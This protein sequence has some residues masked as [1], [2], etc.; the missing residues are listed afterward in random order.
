MGTTRVIVRGLGNVGQD[1]I[2]MINE[3]KSLELVGVLD[4]DPAKVGKDSGVF[5][6]LSANG[7]TVSD[8]VDAVLALPADVVLD[9]SPTLRDD[10]GGFTPSAD[11]ICR[12]LKAGK[13]VITT[14]PLYFLNATAPK[15]YNQLND[16]AKDHGVTFLPTGLLPGAYA[17]YIPIV[18]A[19]IMGRVDSVV[20]ASGED[21]QLNTSSWVTVFGYGMDPATFPA[22]RLKAGI[23]SYYVSAVY[24]MGARLG[25]TFDEVRSTHEVF[26]APQD[27]HPVWGT[28]AKG[29]IYGH[30]FTMSGIVN[31]EAVV[32]LRYVHR[33]CAD[34]VV[35]P[36]IEEHIDIQGLPG[37]LHTEIKGM[38]PFDNGYVTSVAPTINVIPQ[39]VAAAPG[40][41]QAMDLPVVVPIR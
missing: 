13:N 32:T 16:C 9:Y 34:V 26:E 35:E 11:E 10:Q 37:L 30:R 18:L 2:R 24:E 31:G 33:I 23:V 20:V 28:V 12:S 14:I 8:D 15:L 39:V 19:G 1:A 17:S 41:R 27:L 21:D 38:M 5:C 22:H 29:T 7:V 40:Y 4:V 25:L 3:K 6:G 36:V